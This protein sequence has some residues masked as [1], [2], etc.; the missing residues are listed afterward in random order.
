MPVAGS[1]V[2]TACLEM[3]GG[4]Y[5]SS[6]PHYPREDKLLCFFL[7]GPKGSDEEWAGDVLGAKEGLFCL[8]HCLRNLNQRLSKRLDRGGEQMELV[9]ELLGPFCFIVLNPAVDSQVGRSRSC[10]TI[11]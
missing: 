10:L 8:E 6:R 2:G 1:S 5:C 11:S 7:L 9:G 3:V 4:C